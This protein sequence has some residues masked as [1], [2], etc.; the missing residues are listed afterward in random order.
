MRLLPVPRVAWRG[1]GILCALLGALLGQPSLAGA[2][3]FK[4]FST[5]VSVEAGPRANAL[6]LDDG[7]RRTPG[8]A[9]EAGILV[10]T[11]VLSSPWWP[12][13]LSVVGGLWPD[14][15]AT[16]D[17]PVF[18]RHPSLGRLLPNPGILKHPAVGLGMTVEA[19]YRWET[20]TA[21]VPYV[22]GGFF[23]R[24]HK[25]LAPPPLHLNA[26][27][28]VG[29]GLEYFPLHRVGLFLG[30][31]GQGGPMLWP[32]PYV[33]PFVEGSVETLG[34]VRVRLY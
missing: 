20:G 16:P 25:P 11:V 7:T 18:G 4:P 14:F 15:Q 27:L 29:G 30:V 28:R 33:L 26:G 24:T 6:R 3:T 2:S 17:L 1:M 9:A 21:F 10:E 8:G 5:L 12:H 23:F 19:R 13:R 31:H 22:Q 34:G 32:L